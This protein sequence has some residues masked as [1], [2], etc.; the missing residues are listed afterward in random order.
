MIVETFRLAA[1]DPRLA[2]NGADPKVT[3]YLQE[4]IEES[5]CK[6][7][8]RVTPRPSLVICP[9]G[10][11]RH[12]G[13]REGE[14]IALAFMPLGFNCFILDYS[15]APHR[16]PQALKELC[17]LVELIHKNA[18]LW[19]ID[20]SR[21]VLCGFSAGGHLAGSYCTMR[22]RPEIT[23]D[24]PL[25]SI[26]GAILGYSVVSADPSVGHMN[27]F[28]NLLGHDADTPQLMQAYSLETNV[29]KAITPPTFLW[30][31]CTD[32]SVNAVNSLRYGEAL[33]YAGIP[34]EMHIFPTGRHGV[35]T[36]DRQAVH[37]YREA[38]NQYVSQW[39]HLAKGW[40]KEYIL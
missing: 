28:Y 8:L 39:I 4:D 34:F 6:G 29:D 18:E 38:D 31:S 33:Q 14:P 37:D 5:D 7:M 11:Y 17:S 1:H 35:G 16:Y 25:R 21:I 2:Q 9:G 24:Y 23:E 36:A 10:G 22:A 12:V 30:H 32:H 40:L 27:S 13:K 3:M 26:A 19:N 15:V 20:T